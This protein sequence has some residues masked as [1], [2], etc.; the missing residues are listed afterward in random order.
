MN[1]TEPSPAEI[2]SLVTSVAKDRLSE[3]EQGA[4]ALLARFPEVGVL[5]KILGVALLRQG[6]DALQA[7]RRASE[8]L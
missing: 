2:G 6:K 5:W 1:K 7:L 3:A 4:R 8:L